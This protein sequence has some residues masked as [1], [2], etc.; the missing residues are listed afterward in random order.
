[1]LHVVS[2]Q[3]A[4]AH[5]ASILR[6]IQRLEDAELRK[7]KEERDRIEQ[8][9]LRK[10]HRNALREAYSLRLLTN[11]FLSHVVPNSAKVE[12]SP[13]VAVY[14]VRD[15]HPSREN[16]IYTIGGFVGELILVFTALYEY[17]LTNPANSEFKF[18]S[19]SFEKFLVD[20]MKEA[21]FPEAACL[22]RMKDELSEYR[23]RDKDG[24]LD[25]PMTSAQFGT[26]LMNPRN[27]QSFGLNLM[28]KSKK[29][30]LL[31]EQA[32]QEIFQAISKVSLSEAKPEK[33][34]PEEG[35]E[36]SVI[37]QVQ[38]DNEQIRN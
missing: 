1:M 32:L 12:Y 30:I 35:A 23:V 17:I 13:G 7:R 16:G 9:K 6:E 19:E 22:V 2:L 36:Q 15:Y 29:E 10:E 26:A 8:K 20:W 18:T 5:R 21:D 11:K 24:K 27:H 14:D 37:D 31:N 38:T 34:M 28:L 3:K 4:Q 33:P 25:L